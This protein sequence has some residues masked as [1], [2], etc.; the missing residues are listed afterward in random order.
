MAQELAFVLLNPYTLSKSRTGGVVGRLISRTGLNLVAARLFGPSAELAEQ[1]AALV[2]Q[3]ERADG[4]TECVL[5]DYVRRRYGPDARS[6]RRRRVLLL[7]FEGENAV[8]SLYQAVGPLHHNFGSARTVRDVYGD[9]VLDDEGRLQYLEPGVLSAP[10]R[11]STARALQLWG[12]YSAADGGVL[13][14]AWDV[15]GSEACEQTLVL[16]KPDN[17]YFPSARPGSIL[18][19]FSGSGLRIIGAKIHRMSIAEAEEFYGPVR[20]VL[21]RKLRD[22][23]LDLAADALERDL[24]MPLASPVR[25]AVADLLAP[26]YGDHQF[27]Q[28]I[29]FMT[30]RWL[31]DCSAVDRAA[32]GLERCLALIYA[33]PNAVEIIRNILGPTDP[34]KAL[35][36]SV[37]KEFGRDVMVNAAHASDSP[38]NARREI[39]IIRVGEDTLPSWIDK[40]YP[41]KK[42][43]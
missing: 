37:R 9:Y 29:R 32:P 10:D 18:D 39:G 12:A 43:E 25:E 33:G 31:P 19:S 30:G 22:R 2:E 34:S 41:H 21:Q 24:E 14:T 26:L 36:G 8:A 40:H 35:P 1:Y 5:A 15:D 11:E 23:V 7:L 16:I 38:E 6:G 17:F 20:E 28:I 42:K 3:D 4:R 27:Y 13:D